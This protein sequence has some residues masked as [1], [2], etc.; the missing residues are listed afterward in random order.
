MSIDLP[1]FRFEAERM[2]AGRLREAAD[3]VIASNWYVLGPEVIA[4]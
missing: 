1:V 3:R 4:T 2:L